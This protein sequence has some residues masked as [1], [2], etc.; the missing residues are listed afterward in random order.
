M[1]FQILLWFLAFVLTVAGF[2]GLVLPALPGA[3]LLFAGLFAAAWA[4]GFAYVGWITLTLLGVMALSTYFF[5]T[6]QRRPSERVAS[7]GLKGLL[8]ERRLARSW[9]SSSA[10]LASS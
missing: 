3:V 5:W 6:S 8:L 4:E 9:V 10:F 2:A 1:G 7:A